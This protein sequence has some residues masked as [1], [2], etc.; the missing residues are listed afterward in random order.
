M[1]YLSCYIYLLKTN[2]TQYKYLQKKG[3]RFIVKS[4]NFVSSYPFFVNIKVYSANECSNSRD[5]VTAFF[6]AWLLSRTFYFVRDCVM[7]IAF[8]G[9]GGK[10]DE[11]S[12][13]R[14][15]DFFLPIVMNHYNI[16]ACYLCNEVQFDSV[17]LKAVERAKERQPHIKSILFPLPDNTEYNKF[18]Y[19]EV[20]KIGF[21]KVPVD[22]A[23]ILRNEYM[24]K[25]CDILVL[26]E[27]YSCDIT[28]VFRAKAF[29]KALNKTVYEI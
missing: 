18:L 15:L 14:D 23:K 12:A 6:G 24:I 3:L 1:L 29:A 5:R 22:Y 17:A 13:I 7:I 11:E 26:H 16:D 21:D 4:V 8:I 20:Q 19:D 2:S 28:D 10:I 25:E 27:M 9:D